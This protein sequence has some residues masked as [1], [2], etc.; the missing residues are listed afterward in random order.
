MKPV[1]P[2]AV[3]NEASYPLK[4]RVG[5]HHQDKCFSGCED[6]NEAHHG[7]ASSGRPRRQSEMWMLV[8]LEGEG[9]VNQ[10]QLR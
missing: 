4:R 2:P 9:Y 6:L 8:S 3:Y 1:G 10:H 7:R 5:G